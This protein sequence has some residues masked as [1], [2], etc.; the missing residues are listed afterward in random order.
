MLKRKLFLLITSVLLVLLF[1][2]SAYG[3][4]IQ[5]PVLTD[6]EEGFTDFGL[7]IQAEADVVLVSVRF[8]NQGLADNIELLRDSD[9]D[10]LASIPTPAGNPDIIVD[11]NYPLKALEKYRLV[12]TAQNNRFY[13]Y[14]DTPVGN[15]DITVLSSYGVVGGSEYKWSDLWFSFNDITTQ[16]KSAQVTQVVIDIKP[17]DYPNSINLRS[18]GL[19]P[20]AVL[21][22]ED[23]DASSVNP[24]TVQLASASATRW[25]IKD[26][27]GDGNNDMLIFF[28]TEELTGL[29]GNSTDAILTGNTFDGTPFEGTDS[30]NIVPKHK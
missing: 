9:G 20:V 29:S 10:L 30:V 16:P 12:A 2:F 22:T 14:L 23:F 8:P 15:Q 19:V 18:K 17:G 25:I 11:I 21:S 5:G 28:R 27:D 1:S 24:D 7:I 13:G 26:V 3:L 4:V 6:V